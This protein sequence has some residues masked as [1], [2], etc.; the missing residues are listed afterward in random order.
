[1]T[2]K[3]IVKEPAAALF[4]G[5][6]LGA[7]VG[8]MF[9]PWSGKETRQRISDYTGDVRDKAVDYI[10]HGIGAVTHAA[11]QGRDYVRG[12]KSLLVSSFEAGK[13]A[14]EREKERLTNWH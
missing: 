14:Y 2:V 1:M 4:L 6:L 13:K 9:A 7:G 5:G 12:R 11:E 10:D 8:I 3:Q